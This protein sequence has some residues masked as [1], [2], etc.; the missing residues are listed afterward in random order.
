MSS[1]TINFAALMQPIP[2]E[3][4]AGVDV[5]EHEGG[6][7][8]WLIKT[9]REES[10]R[11]ERKYWEEPANPAYSLMN[12]QWD[13]VQRQCEAILVER[14]KDFELVSFLCE[15]LLREHGFAGL[16]DGFRLAR[17]FAEDD[18]IW[19]AAY[20]R[21]DHEGEANQNYGGR[22]RALRELLDGNNLPL[23]LKTIPITSGEQYTTLEYETAQRL[24]TILDPDDR[25]A[26]LIEGMRDV[27]LSV[28]EQEAA[29]TPSAFCQN[30]AADL[31]ATLSELDSLIAVLRE[32]SGEDETGQSAGP[33]GRRTSDTLQ[34][35]LKIV[36]TV[37][38]RQLKSEAADSAP[39]GSTS[40]GG[41]VEASHPGA[42][43]R[44][45]QMTRE[46][47]FELLERAERFLIE[48]EPANP[49]AFQI[50]KAIRCGVMTLPEILAEAIP[51]E[52][53]RQE[54]FLRL[55]IDLPKES[56]GE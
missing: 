27:K 17:Q 9:P 38:V 51:D 54:A 22:V 56:S 18:A 25:K 50:R 20:P 3:N 44:S 35:I 16:R 32:K 2:G 26:E 43:P 19:Q 31:K 55:G 34:E 24:Q 52:S 8:Y 15:A 28:F 6:L 36:R 10:R 41:S 47:A 40:G 33:S 1:E 13:E 7:L 14:S 45:Q 46:L 42:I 12:C 23:A 30:L 37:Y 29:G 4:P 48:T 11:I 21:P 5:R 53:Q 49:A 39:E